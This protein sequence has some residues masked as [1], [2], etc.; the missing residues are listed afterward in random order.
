MNTLKILTKQEA[1]TFEMQEFAISE[2]KKGKEYQKIQINFLVCDPTKGLKVEYV[3]G[4]NGNVNAWV[5]NTKL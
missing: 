5:T 4:R 1:L 3:F 2:L